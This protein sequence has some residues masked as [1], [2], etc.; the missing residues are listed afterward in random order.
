MTY[1][2]FTATIISTVQLFVYLVSTAIAAFICRK[3]AQKLEFIYNVFRRQQQDGF[4]FE[5]NVN[6]PLQ[7]RILAVNPVAID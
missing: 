1:K 2:N 6:P 7:E 3:L 5:E 4:E